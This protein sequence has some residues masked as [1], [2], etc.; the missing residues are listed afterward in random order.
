LPRPR[1]W[2]YL[3]QFTRT[4][5]SSCRCLAL[6]SR[7]L[8]GPAQIY[9]NKEEFTI[10]DILK[11]TARELGLSR[12]SVTST[13]ELLDEGNT[14]PFIARY[15]KEVTG[16]LDETQIRQIEERVGYYR[17][18][19]QRKEEVIRLLDEQGKLTE[20]LQ[21]QING[22]V[23]LTEVEDI[24]RPY[25]PKRKTRASVAREKGLEPLAEYLLSF[26]AA[27]SAE[28]EVGAEKYLTEEVLTVED[29]LQGAMDIIAEDVADEPKV[30]GWVRDH[31]RRNSYLATRAKDLEKDSVY[32]MYYEFKELLSKGNWIYRYY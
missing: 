23:K 7:H 16:E 17:S 10:I 31:T 25:R 4:D 14:V 27:G 29:A 24:Y 8:A 18:L 9:R 15:R 30:R 32:E 22:A 12:K 5:S 3:V 11:I 1:A 6:F 28:V 21:K 2:S 26:P 20:D 19:E 13:V